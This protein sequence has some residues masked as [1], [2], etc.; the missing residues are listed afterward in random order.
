MGS[1]A[2]SSRTRRYALS[3]VLVVLALTV[4]ISGF[5]QEGAAANDGR[6]IQ[7][8]IIKCDPFC[9][10]YDL[11][12]HRQEKLH[13]DD[14]VRIL[15]IKK[16]ESSGL[17]YAGIETKTG[18][19]GYL[20]STYVAEGPANKKDFVEAFTKMLFYALAAALGGFW[21]YRQFKKDRK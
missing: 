6:G 12:S 8:H 17:T 4:S 19:I 7:G 13:N 14:A 18:T 21:T 5:A 16:S 20:P 1:I 10:V 3:A 2:G 9:S 15:E 11:G